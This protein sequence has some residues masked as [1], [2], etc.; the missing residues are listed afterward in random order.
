ML[1]LGSDLHVDW[2]QLINTKSLIFRVGNVAIVFL[3]SNQL[4][5]TF[6]T[7]YQPIK[8]KRK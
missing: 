1:N 6:P 3:S 4:R 8:Q 5:Y 7:V 2:F